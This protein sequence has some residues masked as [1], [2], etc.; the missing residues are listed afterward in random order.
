MN[1]TKK[2]FQA[3]I[4]L[5]NLIAAMAPRVHDQSLMRDDGTIPLRLNQ[6]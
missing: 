1:A 3:I 2:E 6:K 5:P 4:F